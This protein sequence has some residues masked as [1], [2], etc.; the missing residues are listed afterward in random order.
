MVTL[1]QR[2]PQEAFRRGN[3]AARFDPTPYREFLLDLNVGQGGVIELEPGEH[4]RVVKR[5][6]SLVARERQ[7]RTKWL[8]AGPG[9]LRFQLIARKEVAPPTPAPAPAVAPKR[10]RP[11]GSSRKAVRAA[12]K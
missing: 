11:A 6:L 2:L 3:G 12:A 5:R 9:Q 4:Q 1:I 10:G 8:T 7:L